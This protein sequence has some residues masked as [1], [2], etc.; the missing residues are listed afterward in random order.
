MAKR[1]L[2]KV[3]RVGFL[4]LANAFRG[5]RFFGAKRFLYRKAGIRVG[6]ASRIVGPIRVGSEANLSI[7]SNTWIGH[8]LYVEGNGSVSIGDNVDIAPQCAFATGGH[9]IG[10]SEHRAGAGKSFNQ[11]VQDG[12]WVGIRS[13]FVNETHVGKGCV[14]AAGSVVIS[15]VADNMLVGGVPAKRLRALNE[16]PHQGLQ[17]GS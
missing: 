6:D 13:L 17:Q 14:V 3:K 1:V 7:G 12:S 5:N 10:G 16:E 8:D 2:D 11:S 9:E 4:A 15:D